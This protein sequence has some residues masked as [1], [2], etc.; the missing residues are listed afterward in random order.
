M[1]PRILLLTFIFCQYLSSCKQP[2]YPD[3]IKLLME[4][5]GDN[6]KEIQKVVEHYNHDLRDSLKLKAAYFL[7]ENIDNMPTLDTNCVRDNEK[8]F[9]FIGKIDRTRLVFP[10]LTRGMDSMIQQAGGGIP[11]D[12]H[13]KFVN[14]LSTVTADFLIKNID[15]AFY[16]WQN[17]PWSKNISFEDFCEY[18][19]PYRC[20]DTYSTDIREFFLERYRT[21]P[22]TIKSSDNMLKV[23]DFIINDLRPWFKEDPNIL[24][25]Y[26]FLKPIK[27]SDLLKG[28]VGEC[29]DANSVRVAALRAMGIATA[30]DQVP[31]WGNSNQSHYWY[32]ILDRKYD[33]VKSKITNANEERNTQYIISA[34]SFDEPVFEG[35]PPYIQISYGRT[36]PKVYRQYFSKQKSSL[37]WIR[38]S[39]EIPN[40]FKDVRLKDVTSEYIET[41]TVSIALNGQYKEHQY[42]YLCV[43]DNQTWIPVAW[44]VIDDGKAAFRDMGKNIVYLPAYYKEG[45]L[46][47]AESP[48]L[49][50]LEGRIEKISPVKETETV[51]VFTKFPL[52]TYIRKW[53]SLV[54]GGRLQLANKPDF[55]DSLTV[56]TIRSLPFYETEIKLKTPLQARF[57]LF[58]FK[59]LSF[60]EFSELQ[61]YGLDKN[62]KEILLKGQSIGNPGYYPY[63]T[64]KLFD[65]IPYNFYR[66]DT[67]LPARYVGLDLGENNKATITRIRYMPYS[68]DNAVRQGDA[69]RLAYW[70][71]GW[72]TLAD[73]EAPTSNISFKNVPKGALLLLI[74]TTGGIQQRIF[75]YENEKQIFW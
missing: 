51:K 6:K 16:M 74:N 68:D 9:D 3:H 63:Q 23:G 56:H 55:S 21:L 14:E 1:L 69:Y 49:F 12:P 45:K 59:G 32:K 60:L 66:A 41:A 35:T 52:R 5:A 18:I 11:P 46:V 40:Y 50:T 19:L 71:N 2:D 29:N 54:I 31:N 65:G 8:Y 43:F 30:Y 70:D 17:M 36:V 34:T 72:K 24:L 33:T 28:R 58:Q 73:A 38:G 42:A 15:S 64:G 25:K 62:G 7:I 22:D 48:F 4:K 75:R 27:F 13:V 20:T 39:A 44:S 57:L 10:V 47:P 37:A 61:F 67:S 53:Q 26:P